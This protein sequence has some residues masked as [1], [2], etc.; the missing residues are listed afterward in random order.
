MRLLDRLY[1][2]SDNISNDTIIENIGTIG[3][4]IKGSDLISQNKERFFTNVLL[5]SFNILR[6][7]YDISTDFLRL[8]IKRNE[9]LFDIKIEELIS[10]DSSYLVLKYGKMLVEEIRC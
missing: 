4:Y 7:E 10:E 8:G 6:I 1:Q 2:I 5:Q 9:Y 3:Y